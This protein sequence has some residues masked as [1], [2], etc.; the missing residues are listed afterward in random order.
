MAQSLF[1]HGQVISTVQKVKEVRP[2]AERLITLAKRA[3]QGSLPDRQRIIALL[4]DRAVI[5]A[6][7]LEDYTAGSDAKRHKVLRARSG[8]RYRTGQPKGS[9]SYTAQS[10]VHRLIND[11][12]PKLEDRAGGYTRIIRLGRPRIGDGGD[13]A[14]LQLVGD[15]KPPTGLTKPGKSARA[16]R[17]EARYAFAARALRAQGKKTARKKKGQDEPSVAEVSDEELAAEPA[18]PEAAAGESEAGED[19]AS[20]ND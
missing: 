10:V 12:A 6:D 2:F 5:P 11:V 15:E 16:R 7:H 3:H 19:D 18:E 1:E 17:I 9:L 4:N 14:V 20:R 8:R 13:R